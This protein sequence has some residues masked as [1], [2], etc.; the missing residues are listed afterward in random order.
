[1]GGAANPPREERLMLRFRSFS[2]R[3]L[4][5]RPTGVDGVLGGGF[6]PEN[7]RLGRLRRLKRSGIQFFISEGFPRNGG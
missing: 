2:E 4:P 6:C 1:M 7:E 3:R 5:R